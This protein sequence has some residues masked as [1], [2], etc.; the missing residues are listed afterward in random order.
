MKHKILATTA[1]AAVFSAGALS[2]SAQEI[3]IMCTSDGAECEVLDELT[4]RFEADHPGVDVV[5][6]VVPYQAVLESLPVQLAAGTGPDLAMVTDLGGL[7]PYYLDLAPYVDRDY[8]ES[9]FG[10]VLGWYRASPDDDGIYGLHMLL[11]ITGAYINRT[12]FEQAGVEVP[13]PDASWDDWAEASRAVAEATDTTF[14]MAMDRS[15]HRIAGPAISYGAKIFDEDGEPILVDDAFTAYVQKF[16]DW[17]EDGTMARDVWA[18]QG[19]DSYR[20]AAQEFI[21]GELVYYYSGSWQTGRFDE[22]IGDFF[23]WQ[24]V[25]SPCGEGGCTGMPGGSGL[26]GFKQTKHPEIVA[27]LMDYLA[28]QEIYAE[29]SGRTRNIP[30]HRAVA[31][32]GADYE[33]ASEPAATALKTWGAQ[34]GRVSPIAFAYQGYRNNRAMFNIT[35][36][37]ATQAVVGELTVEEAMERAE[38]DLA[39][40]LAETK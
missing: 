25:G 28:Q 3:R 33:G 22:Q 29:F 1:F 34:V 38:A 4:T 32:A 6:D 30:A 19:G 23:D 21:N 5:M 16:V 12:L 24:V 27:A 37:R 11:T 40:V 20:D 31:S 13:G 17:H 7:N 8:W 18:G 2:A 9:S 36:Q 14:P 39:A 15:G 10:D 35:V 26:V